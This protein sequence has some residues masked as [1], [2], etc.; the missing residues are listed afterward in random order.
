MTFPPPLHSACLWKVMGGW[1]LGQSSRAKLLCMPSGRAC[2]NAR[3]TPHPSS[4]GS[5]ERTLNPKP[6]PVLELLNYP[7]IRTYRAYAPDPKPETPKL[8]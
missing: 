2:G 8:G 7:K 1:G 5:K 3:P 4:A 6:T